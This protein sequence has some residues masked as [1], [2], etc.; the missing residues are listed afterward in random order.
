MFYDYDDYWAEPNEFEQQIEE[1]KDSLRKDVRAEIKERIESL[2]KE[3][4][5]LKA[6]KDDKNKIIQEYENKFKEIKREAD[7]KIREAKESEEKMKK[8]RLHQLLGEYLTVGWKVKSVWEYGEKCDKC[9]DNRKIHF[10]SPQG[11]KYVEECQC[12]NRHYKYFPVEAILS[13]IYVRKKNFSWN[14]KGETDFYNRYY[15]VESKEKDDYD[16]Y[17]TSSEVY[18]SSDIDFEKVNTYRAVFLNEED[19]KKYCDWINEKKQ[20]NS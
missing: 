5:E 14:D 8:A 16:I 20:K 15:T 12:A 17:E 18:T 6:Y 3:L 1:F 9:D 7:K 10:T 2:E 13:K 11:K 4:S 19:C